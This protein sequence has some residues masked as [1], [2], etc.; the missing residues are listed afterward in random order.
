[1]NG[2]LTQRWTQST[3]FFPKSG[4][5]FWFPKKTRVAS[6]LLSSSGPV[7]VAE[8]ASISLDMTKYYWKCLTKLFWLCQGSEFAWS[9][10]MFDRLLKMPRVLNKPGFRIWHGCICKGYAEFQICLIMA[11]DAPIMP[12][13][14]SICLNVPHYARARLNI[15]EYPWLYLKMPK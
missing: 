11:P 1:M 10:Y 14:D 5:F 7:S 15:A 13:H 8:Y 9:S 6:P 3:L 12:K 2:K 4:H